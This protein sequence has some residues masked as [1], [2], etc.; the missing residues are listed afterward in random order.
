MAQPDVA[1]D[2]KKLEGLSRQ[3]ASIESTVLSFRRYKED[4]GRP[5]AGA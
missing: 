3:R 4:P 5:A 2:Y 1:A